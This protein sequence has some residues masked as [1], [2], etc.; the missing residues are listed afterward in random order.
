[1]MF[2]KPANDVLEVRNYEP[3]VCGNNQKCVP[4]QYEIQNPRKN[5]LFYI[6]DSGVGYRYD[7][8]SRSGT[9]Y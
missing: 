9:A 6:I 4:L 2:S 3:N 7:P 5:N 8:A 1:M